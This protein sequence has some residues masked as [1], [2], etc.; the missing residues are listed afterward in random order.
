MLSLNL[1]MPALLILIA[2]SWPIAAKDYPVAETADEVSATDVHAL[3]NKAVKTHPSVAAAE[4][5]VFG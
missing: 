4:A 5:S 1:K 3:I 2:L